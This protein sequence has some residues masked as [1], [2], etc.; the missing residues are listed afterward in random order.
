[1]HTE[2]AFGRRQRQVITTVERYS[3]TPSSEVQIFVVIEVGALTPSGGL[4]N[5]Y[6][7]V[8]K[9]VIIITLKFY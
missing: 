7:S 4:A 3:S 5:D 2:V 8:L 9:I 1:M 6:L